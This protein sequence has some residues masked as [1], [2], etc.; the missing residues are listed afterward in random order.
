[1][2]SCTNPIA[3]MTTATI[4]IGYYHGLLLESINADMLSDKLCSAGLLTANEQTIISSIN[5]D[6]HKNWLLLEHVQHMNVPALEK[7]CELVQDIWPLIGSQL[8]AGM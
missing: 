4:L 5:S 2:I 8:I 1:M 3:M 7:F 6:Y